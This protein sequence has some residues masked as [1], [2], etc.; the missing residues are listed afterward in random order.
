MSL[1]EKNGFAITSQ[2]ELDDALIYKKGKQQVI[3]QT[4]EIGSVRYFIVTASN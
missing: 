1:L 3:M 2:L 4:K